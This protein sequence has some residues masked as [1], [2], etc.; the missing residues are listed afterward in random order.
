MMARCLQRPG[1][2]GAKAVEIGRAQRSTVPVE[3]CGKSH[4]ASFQIAKRIAPAGISG[5]ACNGTV[6]V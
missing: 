3:H 1:H 5:A 6:E 2:E 4:V